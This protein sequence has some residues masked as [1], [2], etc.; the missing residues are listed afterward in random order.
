MLHLQQERM[1]ANP[2]Y[3]YMSPLMRFSYIILESNKKNHFFRY[4]ESKFGTISFC[5]GF[6]CDVCSDILTRLIYI[7]V[8]F[9]QTIKITKNT[10]NQNY[11]D[12][13]TANKQQSQ[14]SPNPLQSFQLIHSLPLLI[15]SLTF[16]PFLS[17]FPTL[18]GLCD[19]RGTVIY[20]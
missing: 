16:L 18:I 9:F 13:I 15:I 7:L 20:Q 17:S 8:V 3:H 1:E 2:C 4:S 12:T 6:F 11:Q 14:P 5:Y 19:A 10:I